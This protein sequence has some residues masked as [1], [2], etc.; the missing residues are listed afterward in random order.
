ML[1]S[2]HHQVLIE[3]FIVGREFSVET[4]TQNNETSIVA[5][6]E[7]MVI[8]EKQGYFVEDTHIEPARISEQE[9]KL[10]ADT[11]LNAIKL[12]G[13]DNCPSHTE[14]KLND[15]GAYII[16]IACRLGGDYITSFYRC[17]YVGKSNKLFIRYA[18]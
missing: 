1:Y 13:L 7:K 16:E 12:I 17:R 11:V 9:Y 2:R 18:Y 5:I 15:T 8:G 10:I 6:T 14:V 4:F 3:D